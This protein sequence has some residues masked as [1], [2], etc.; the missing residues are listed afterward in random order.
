[1]AGLTET[2]KTRKHHPPGRGFRN[3]RA[4]RHCGRAAACLGV[5][6]LAGPD[7]SPPP[8]SESA[9]YRRAW[10]AVQVAADVKTRRFAALSQRPLNG[11]QPPAGPSCLEAANSRITSAKQ[12]AESLTLNMRLRP[13]CGKK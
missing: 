10:R 8:H 13:Y 3:V 7:P 12:G 5:A 11:R 6:E 4:E 2:G 9:H 1:M